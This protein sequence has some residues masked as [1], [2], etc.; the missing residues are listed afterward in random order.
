MAF[1]FRFGIVRFFDATVD[2]LLYFS[3]RTD[4]RFRLG[5]VQAKF[6]SA[7]DFR[8]I[9]P[10]GEYRMRFGNDNQTSLLPLRSPFAIFDLRRIQDASRQSKSCK[11]VCSALDFRYI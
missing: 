11:P 3:Y 7:L 9:C 2:L 5:I 1:P 6:G 4:I 10:I 8:Y